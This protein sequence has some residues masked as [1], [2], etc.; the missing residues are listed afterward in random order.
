MSDWDDD[1]KDYGSDNYNSDYDDPELWGG[2]DSPPHSPEDDGPVFVP[3]YTAYE[4]AGLGGAAAILDGLV[5][6]GNMSD[7]QKKINR[8]LQD[9]V[10]RFAIYVDATSRRLD[11]NSG[12]SISENDIVNMLTM[13]KNLKYVQ[14]TNPEAYVLGFLASKGGVEIHKKNIDKIF[15]NALPYTNGVEKADVIRYARLWLNL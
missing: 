3:S 11:G 15:K 14:Y 7:L 10:E 6:S 13:I 1:Y 9:P 12:I 8:I 2:N 4:R 5:L